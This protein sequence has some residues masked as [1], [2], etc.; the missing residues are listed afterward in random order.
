MK[1]QFI[2]HKTRLALSITLIL[3]VL[4]GLP[5]ATLAAAGDNTLVSVDSSGVQANGDSNYFSISSD[6]RYVAFQSSATNLVAGDTNG[7]DDIFVRDTVANTT[8]RVS[9]GNGIG[10]AQ[11]NGASSHPSISANAR[12]VAFQS[13]ANNLVAGDANGQLDVFVRDTVANTTTRVS[14]NS[15]SMEATGG[16]DGSS[17]PSISGDGRFV[18][19][20][21]DAVNLV[22]GD[23]NS[24]RDVFVRDI[25]AG[26]TTR[27]SVDSSGLQAND[28]SYRPSISYEGRYVAFDSFASNL[29]VG[30]TNGKPDVFVRDTVANT[31]TRVSVDSSGVQGNGN[32]LNP[33]I[34][35]DGS[36]VAFYSSASNLVSG[37]TNGYQDVFVHDQTTGTTARVSVD[38]SGVQADNAS[39]IYLPSISS[40]GPYVTFYSSATNLVAGDTN[41]SSDVFVRDFERNTTTRVSLGTGGAQANGALPSISSDGRYI[42]FLSGATNLVGVDT[43]GKNDIFVHDTGDPII[44][45][46]T[47][48]SQTLAANGVAS[49]IGDVTA[50]NWTSFPGLYFEKRT[51]V[52]DPTTAIGKIMFN[53][54][55]DLSNIET[56]TF[57]QSLWKYVDMAAGRIAFD[58]RTS[59]EFRDH[60][61][62]LVMYDLPLGLTIDNL[63]V[64]DDS[65]MILDT[66]TVVSGFTQDPGSGN[67]TFS[68][69]HFTQFDFDPTFQ[70]YLPLVIR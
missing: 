51:N 36:Y 44:N 43:N 33:S 40:E 63:T 31:T 64:R 24:M 8:T 38:S 19:F 2:Q 35:G 58:A 7:V 26:T 45:I 11:A 10:G 55:V 15:I 14:V 57:L 47:H 29:V 66:S 21:S 5:G 4:L 69:A 18:A 25:G 34:S 16:I 3:I 59:A 67:V 20:F 54:A 41:G 49:N 65:G 42:A 22:L 32:S 46:F 53:S 23:T 17:N 68:A 52:A 12:Y 62:T 9:V 70:I 39:D 30:D 37:D 60:G 61:A 48:I 13:S 6:A 1:S 50:S 27:I 56:Q 28:G